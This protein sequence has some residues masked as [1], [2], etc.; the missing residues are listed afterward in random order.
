MADF[1]TTTFSIDPG[2]YVYRE[3]FD[4]RSL[5]SLADLSVIAAAKTS[6]TTV[7]LYFARPLVSFDDDTSRYAVSG[8]I[9]VDS[10]E[11]NEGDT[12]VTLNVSGTFS[13]GNYTVTVQGNTVVSVENYAN[14]AGSATLWSEGEV[15]C[16]DCGDEPA[17]EDAAWFTVNGIETKGIV[18]I[19]SQPAGDR[20]DVGA[21]HGAADGSLTVTRQVRKR[22]FK[23]ATTPL[24]AARARAWH[25]LLTGEGHV[26]SFDSH[27]YSSKGLPGTTLFPLDVLV[28]TTQKKFGAG[29]LSVAFGE[30][31][32]MDVD[33]GDE[34]TVSVWGRGS[35]APWYHYVARSD[36]AQWVDGVRNDAA[37]I[38][39][40]VFNVTS[41]V[42]RLEVLGGSIQTQ[43]YDDVVFCPYLWPTDWAA[44]VYASGQPFGP[45]PFLTTAGLLVPEADT[46]TMLC[47]KCD[48]RIM[49]ATIDGARHADLRELM[50][51]LKGA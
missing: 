18:T 41:G 44:Q 37:E 17:A 30:T 28:Q 9:T 11:M 16:P 6:A 7:R 43:Y 50:V 14:V 24:T 26:W 4:L 51:E 2:L 13:P 21:Q 46:R 12:F 22:D 20:R 5:V 27:L 48:E 19:A 34:W 29:A 39:L 45:A 33:A 35:S 8:G 40:G 47:S 3:H 42:L 38:E 25:G 32:E 10:V 31:L 36:G 15:E 49:M 23:F 1:T